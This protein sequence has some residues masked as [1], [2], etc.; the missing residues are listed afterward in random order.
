MP[1]KIALWLDLALAAALGSLTPFT[2]HAQ[3]CEAYFSFDG[4]LANARGDGPD[5]RMI[6]PNGVAAA[7][8]F[9]E[10]GQEKVD[11]IGQLDVAELVGRDVGDEVVERTH[12]GS[13][14]K[15]ERLKR[16]AHARR[17]FPELAA[18][19][20]LHGRGRVR[21]GVFRYR[22]AARRMLLTFQA[23]ELHAESG[24]TTLGGRDPLAHLP[25]RVVPNVL[26]MPT[27]QLGHPVPFIVLVVPRDRLLHFTSDSPP[28]NSSAITASPDSRARVASGVP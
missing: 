19:Q 3:T 28:M 22:S 18:E 11:C 6:G 10:L 12:L 21:R 25:R 8:R 14:A 1:K 16:V 5:G 17:H 27:R 4:T 9:V 26:A 24:V 23:V 20:F 13:A 7:P 15:I 2:A